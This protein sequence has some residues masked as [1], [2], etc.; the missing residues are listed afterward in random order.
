MPNRFLL[1]LQILQAVLDDGA[2]QQ[3]LKDDAHGFLSEKFDLQIP[4]GITIDVIEETPEQAYIVLPD[5]NHEFMGE[6]VSGFVAGKHRKAVEAHVIERALTNPTWRE[7]VFF[8]DPTAGFIKALGLNPLLL[9][10]DFTVTILQEDE[11]HIYL[12]LPFYG[13]SGILDARK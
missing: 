11:Q 5:P 13:R 8:D 2:A 3:A 10:A 6:L 4:S 9:P 12:V 1:E 7:T